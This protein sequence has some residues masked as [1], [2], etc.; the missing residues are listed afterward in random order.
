MV[1]QLRVRGVSVIWFDVTATMRWRRPPSGMVRT[2]IELSRQLLDGI[3]GAHLCIFRSGMFVPVQCGTFEAHVRLLESPESDAP[4]DANAAPGSRFHRLYA[5]AIR[6]GPGTARP[7]LRFLV[8]VAARLRIPVDRAT[9]EQR[10]AAAAVGCRMGRGDIYISFGADWVPEDKIGRIIKL[11]LGGVRTILCCYDLI[12]LLFPHLSYDQTAIRFPRYLSQLADAADT[13]LCISESTRNDFEA[14]VARAGA[15]RPR[16]V[17]IRLGTDGR[18]LSSGTYDLRHQ[19]PRDYILYVSTLERRKNHETLYKAYVTIHRSLGK[20][21]PVC[22]LVGAKGWGV[23]DALADMTLDPRV[24]DDFLILNRVSDGELQ[25]LYEN[26]LFTVFPSLYEGWGLP[27]A[28]SLRNEKFVLASNRSSIPEAGGAFAEYIE[29]WDVAGWAARIMAYTEDR[30]Q[31]R[32][33]EERIRSEYS[34]PTWKDAFAVL[35]ET[36]EQ[37]QR[38]AAN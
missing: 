4:D 24:K 14:F 32:E 21:P 28:E 13:I 18:S 10:G 2:Q 12:P 33:R 37:E 26:C 15:A 25:W 34:P 27:V 22:V 1:A 6:H 36:V 3:D 7:V 35:L 17:T 9:R 19:I 8:R 38:A 16:L 23:E 30:D 20:V 29:P 11:R 31:L 5:M